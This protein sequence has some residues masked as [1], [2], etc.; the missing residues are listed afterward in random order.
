MADF[1]EIRAFWHW[2]ERSI[3][4][5]PDADGVD[6]LRRL[7]EHKREMW[8]EEELRCWSMLLVD[9]N[10]KALEFCHWLVQMLKYQPSPVAAWALAGWSLW[11]GN[12]QE[13]TRLISTA[14]YHP[15]WLLA[16]EAFFLQAGDQAGFATLQQQP[17]D[18]QRQPEVLRRFPW[19]IA[20][21]PEQQRSEFCQKHPLLQADLQLYTRLHQKLSLIPQPAPSRLH[22][23]VVSLCDQAIS[24]KDEAIKKATQALAQSFIELWPDCREIANKLTE[25]RK[26]SGFACMVS[27]SSRDADYRYFKCTLQG[28]ITGEGQGEW[29]ECVAKEREEFYRLLSYLYE[30]GQ[31]SLSIFTLSQLQQ[32]LGKLQLRSIHDRQMV[33]LINFQA[34]SSAVGKTSS[35]P[36]RKIDTVADLLEGLDECIGLDQ[37]A[38]EIRGNDTIIDLPL[39]ML[40]LGATPLAVRVNLFKAVAG[41]QPRRFSLDEPTRILFL[42]VSQKGT[43]KGHDFKEIPEAKIDKMVNALNPI[44]PV[45]RIAVQCDGDQILPLAN[46]DAIGHY[47]IVHLLCHGYFMS[48][49]ELPYG[50]LLPDSQGQLKFASARALRNFLQQVQPALLFLNTCVSAKT[51]KG[52]RFCHGMIAELLADIPC[53]VAFRWSVELAMTAPFALAFYQALQEHKHPVIAMRKAR[54]SFYPQY[55]QRAENCDWLAPVLIYQG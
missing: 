7:Y 29:D 4:A 30:Q 20:L 32:A 38:L 48:G 47:D 5:T 17:L 27:L 23:L 46:P 8:S 3:Q 49:Q 6:L 21:V 10:G 45:H 40:A 9:A 39:D 14:L 13:H 37:V 25:L 54:H 28:A 16:A 53:L 33:G 19:F 51:E 42:G 50:V 2:M 1:A 11:R 18:W 43:V 31:E 41:F 35:N 22:E 24:Q 52:S 26:F 55:K 36:E 44:Y 15:P 12:S 34:L